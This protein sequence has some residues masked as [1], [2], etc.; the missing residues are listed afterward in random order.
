VLADIATGH[1]W[2]ADVCF[3]LAMI[4]AVVSAALQI[5]D[6]RPVGRAAPADGTLHTIHAR[7]PWASVL[8]ALSLGF[9]ALGLLI[10]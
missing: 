1:T 7:G 10:L 4:L 5:V 9:I 3:L 2:G 8:L 6:A